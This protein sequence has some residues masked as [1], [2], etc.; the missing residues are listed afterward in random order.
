[1]A[2]NVSPFAALTNEEKQIKWMEYQTIR[3]PYTQVSSQAG[4]EQEG[5]KALSEEKPTVSVHA[6]Y[7]EQQLSA[8]AIPQ[9]AQPAH[10]HQASQTITRDVSPNPAPSRPMPPPEVMFHPKKTTTSPTPSKQPTPSTYQ[11]MNAYQKSR[12]RQYDTVIERMKQAEKKTGIF[13]DW[14]KG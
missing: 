8:Q 11:Q 3:L 13:H 14:S 7:T 9:S 4:C 1:M 5:T 12:H 6:P 10:Q 2:R